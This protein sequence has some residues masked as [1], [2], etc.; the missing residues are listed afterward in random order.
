MEHFVWLWIGLIVLS[1]VI[2]VLTEQL[3]SIWFIPGALVAAILSLC[4]VDILWQAFGFVLI[5][6]IFV[7]L[8]KILLGKH[9]SSDD[10]RTNIDAIIGEK[11][12]VSERIDN[13]AGCGLVRIKGQFWSARGVNETDTFEVGEVL[14]VVAIE[15]VKLICK[16]I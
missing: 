5:S 16:K 12:V 2:E 1:I 4:T 11:C 8:G 13:F 10:T 14:S 15:G 7:P 6:V 9:R 3:I